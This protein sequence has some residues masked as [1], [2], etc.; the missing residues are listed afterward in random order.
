ML[1]FTS[2][3]LPC[4]CSAGS[5]MALILMPNNMLYLAFF[6]CKSKCECAAPYHR[7]FN[8]ISCRLCQCSLGVPQHSPVVA[9]L[10]AHPCRGAPDRYFGAHLLDLSVVPRQSVRHMYYCYRGFATHFTDRVA[11]Q[12]LSIWES[13]ESGRSWKP[14]DT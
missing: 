9:Q 7:G 12:F 1:S 3:L 4:L 13:R 6:F 8:Q 10:R 14:L 11:A 5:L 2:G